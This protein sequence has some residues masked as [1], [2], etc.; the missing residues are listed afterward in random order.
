MLVEPYNIKMSAKEYILIS[1][2][3]KQL[4]MGDAKQLTDTEYSKERLVER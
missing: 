4:N 1:L 2:L 3:R